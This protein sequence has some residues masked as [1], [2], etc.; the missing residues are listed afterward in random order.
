VVI[1]TDILRE[2]YDHVRNANNIFANHRMKFREWVIFTKILTWFKVKLIRSN[3][4]AWL[5]KLRYF[6][7]PNWFKKTPTAEVYLALN[8]PYSFMLI[9]VLPELEKRF[10][11]QFKL[12]LVY[13]SVPGVTIDPKLMRAWAIKDANYIADQYQLKKITQQ[14]TQE[15]LFTGQQ[16]WQ[17]RPKTLANAWQ[18]FQQTWFNEFDDYYHASTPVINYQI[19]NLMR[20]VK[21]GHYLPSSIFIAGKWFVGIDRLDHLEKCLTDFDLAKD[22]SSPVYQ[23]NKL[24]F[25]EQV[26]TGAE[27]DNND[28]DILEAFISLRSPYSYIGLLQAEKLSQHYQIPLKIKPILPLLMR[29]L[30]T[31][32]NKQRYAVFDASREANK[33]EVP[34]TGITDPLGQGIINAFQVFAYADKENKG[35]AF[36]KSAFNAIYVDGL[37][38]SQNSV[39][40]SLCKQHKLN[41]EEALEHNNEHDWQQWSDCNQA[42]LDGMGLWGAP[43]FRF[44][45]TTCWGQDRLAQIEQA[46]ITS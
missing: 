19:K 3:K 24:V 21:L 36:I 12:F 7:V 6:T 26:T 31:T 35:L 44:K 46:I 41:Y 33:L 5:L 4:R 23:K 34:F 37:D 18:L 45:E 10:N 9:Q 22:D 28:T 32:E 1:I 13:E 14:P 25:A 11:I 30:T 38:L 27:V 15:S 2:Y 40:A 8:D 29:G 43:C 20:L 42:S 16:M 17:L 39:I